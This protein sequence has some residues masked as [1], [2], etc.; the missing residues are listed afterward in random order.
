[1]KIL[2]SIHTQVLI[3]ITV[4]VLWRI[5]L[6]WLS[7]SADLFLVYQPSFPYF[8]ILDLTG[9][10]RWLYSWANFDGVHYLRIADAGYKGGAL[11]QAFFPVYPLLLRA[12][13]DFFS[14]SFFVAG[15][16]V[17]NLMF[18]LLCITF[19]VYVAQRFTVQLAWRS[20]LVL[21][22]FPSSF[23][24]VGVYTESFFITTCILAFLFARNK[25]WLWAGVMIIIAS[26]TRVVGIL[27]LPALT[28]DLFFQT[29][30]IT[31]ETTIYE[32]FEKIL[33]L[34]KTQWYNIIL[35]LAGAL[36][37]TS[38]MGYLW[39]HYQDPLYFFHV[40]SEFSAGRQ[41]QIIS[42]PQVVYRYVKILWTVRPLDWKYYAYAQE[43]FLSLS[44]FALI[45]YG[46]IH[47]KYKIK[48]SELVF[49][50]SALL[51]PTMTGTF[52]SMTRYVLVCFPLF[53]LIPQILKKRWQ[54]ALYVSCSAVF[55]CINT[56]LFIQG[57]WV[58]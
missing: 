38:Y 36:G 26:A 35:I 22:L 58:G 42:L 33:D 31:R 47:R 49:C 13:A 19:F 1:M 14:L 12:I 45:I 4:V 27:L 39:Q 30:K 8:N 5:M 21:L 53:I 55:L 23:F 51:L 6:F 28:V 17:S 40:Q 16:I 50:F 37:L 24:F 29:Y 54:F 57:Y 11:I 25:W 18:L 32:V 7:Y 43:L 56:I 20:L 15:M 9:F 34:V 10:P 46:L 52:S 3:V 44:A 2:K 48:I 41:E